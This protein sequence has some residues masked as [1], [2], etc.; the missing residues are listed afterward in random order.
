[1]PNDKP[2]APSNLY[3]IEKRE[4]EQVPE[5]EITIP[6]IE[7]TVRVSKERIEAARVRL[8]KTVD[9]RQEQV[10]L[11]LSEEEITVVRKPMNH[12][13]EEA[14]G[15]RQEGNTTIYSVLKEVLVVEKKLMLVEEIHV[16][17]QERTK[18]ANQTVQLRSESITVE[19]EVLQAERPG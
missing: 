2:S 3:E 14:P 19:R 4:N 17:K 11:P 1:M 15:T 6:V 10:T 13:V 18:I 9:K 12:Y 8:I 5:G 7:E 16:T